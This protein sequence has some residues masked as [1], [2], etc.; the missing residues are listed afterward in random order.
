MLIASTYDSNE[1]NFRVSEKQNMVAWQE[2]RLSIYFEAWLDR[3]YFKTV[4]S[5]HQGMTL[6]FWEAHQKKEQP[7]RWV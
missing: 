2:V 5:T 3:M 6:V 7:P 1:G 4:S